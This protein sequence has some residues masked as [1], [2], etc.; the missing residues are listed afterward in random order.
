MFFVV[1]V[2]F[3]I[4]DVSTR[5]MYQLFRNTRIYE[6]PLSDSN[7]VTNNKTGHVLNKDEENTQADAEAFDLEEYIEKLQQERKNWEQEYRNRKSQRKNLTKRKAIVES[8][9]QSLNLNILTESERAFILARPNYENICKKSQKLPEV[10]LKISAL[11]K[12][13]HKLNQEFMETIE[14]N[15]SRATRDIIEKLEY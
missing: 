6:Y 13:V 7:E 14:N 11:S 5:R 9:R 1:I 12:M 15:I 2:A 3:L 8:Q 10:V 4:I